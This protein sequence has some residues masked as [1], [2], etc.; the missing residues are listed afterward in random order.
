MEQLP[1]ELGHR[2]ALGRDDFLVSESNRDAVAWID[3]WPHWPGPGLVVFGPAASGKSHLAEVWRA[4]SDAIRID[5]M[6]LAAD[7][8]D[9]FAAAGAVVI[10]DA[11]RGFDETALFHL[12]NILAERKAS[13]LLTAGTPP[14]RWDLRLADLRS[15]LTALPA[16]AIV[17]PD[18]ALMHAVLVKLFAD[19]Q[20]RVDPE[21]VTYLVNR[22]DRSLAAA[23]A[24]VATLDRAALAAGRPL[25][26][27]FARSALRDASMLS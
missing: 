15:R 16:V 24:A 10:E 2:A 17:A 7:S 4:R 23:A 27:P 26:V 6:N 20:L 14:A 1:L 12:Y 18:D 22:L 21:L 13:L 25:T 9:R 5:R 19:R 11:D 3:L 8:V